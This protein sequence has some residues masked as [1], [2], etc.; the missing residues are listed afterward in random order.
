[1]SNFKREKLTLDPIRWVSPV[2]KYFADLLKAKHPIGC[3]WPV[4]NSCPPPVAT[5]RTVILDPKG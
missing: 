1:M 5:C 2:A 3:V 4:R